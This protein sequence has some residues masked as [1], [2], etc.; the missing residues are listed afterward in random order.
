MNLNPGS[1]KS[2]QLDTKLF[3]KIFEPLKNDNV[4]LYNHVMGI[5]NKGANLERDNIPVTRY[6]PNHPVNNEIKIKIT[7]KLM[8]HIKKGQ[9]A[10]PY[11]SSQLPFNL[12]LSPIFG[13][14]KDNG[15]VRII[16][17][18]S[19]P[20]DNS[21]N[22]AIP[23]NVRTVSLTTFPEVC[24]LISNI[25]PNGFIWII[26]CEDAYWRL[27]LNPNDY[28]LFGIEWL[29]KERYYLASQ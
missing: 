22:S 20:I 12:T 16:V 3:A 19:S 25:G 24:Q 11:T 5:V 26:D 14:L 21:I 18:L 6:T 15:K 8:K 10:G 13:N 1:F 2:S 28:H 9:I 29:G 7:Q 17:D 23:D 4:N 27:P